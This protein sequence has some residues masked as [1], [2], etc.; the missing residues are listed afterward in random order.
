MTD[1]NTNIKQITPRL[2][3]AFAILIQLAAAQSLW[4]VTFPDAA[5][6]VLGRYSL[7]YFVASL[8][9][10]L[11][12]L[13]LVFAWLNWN[14]IAQFLDNISGSVRVGLIVVSGVAVAV[15]W[16]SGFDLRLL[17]Y[18]MVNWVLF[19]TV[20]VLTLP[21]RNWN[22][23]WW[24][25]VLGALVIVIIGLVAW[26]AIFTKGAFLPYD[27]S[28]WADYATSLF[29]TGGVHYRMYLQDYAVRPGYP[30][31]P[32]AY[33]WLLE[34][35]SYDARVG[36]I[37][38]LVVYAIALVGIWAI[39]RK[40]YSSS[41]AWISA[42]VAT[43]SLN[44]IAQNEFRSHHHIPALSILM[45]WC[46]WQARHTRGRRGLLW[47][48]AC[49]LLGSL[50]M[51]LHAIAYMLL[52]AF[53]IHLLI[54]AAL[55]WWRERDT[56][57]FVQVVVFGVG[58]ALGLVVYYFL[59]IQPV[60]GL[61]EFLHLLSQDKPPFGFRFDFLDFHLYESASLYSNNDRVFTMLTWAGLLYLLWR[62][63]QVDRW[64]LRLVVLVIA[65]AFVLD[66]FGYTAL[67]TSYFSIAIGVLLAQGFRLLTQSQHW[68]LHT[69]G[70]VTVVIVALVIVLA[71]QIVAWGL[72]GDWVRTG[73]LPN[74]YGDFVEIG[75]ILESEHIS[76]D[77]VIV[78][79]HQLMWGL[80]RHQSLYSIFAEQYWMRIEEP[81][82]IRAR[83][84]ALEPTVY[85][86]VDDDLFADAIGRKLI[87]QL[88]AHLDDREFA[89]CDSFMVQGFT[90]EVYRPECAA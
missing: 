22:P 20:L 45:L 64:F 26:T 44:F 3:V 7:P 5:A 59:N 43:L 76:D 70:V 53:G 33:G 28:S 39:A 66:F 54:D 82:A 19:A 71:T 6:V 77:D 62:R 56:Y 17:R 83:W 57:G 35:V 42:I 16:A 15:L 18:A 25:V 23:T 40:M 58:A 89:L 27:E 84:D 68:N 79:T 55:A 67:Y 60:G 2:V 75:A 85:I 29:R 36:H 61:E 48:F 90:V 9:N 37:W 31:I 52:G 4:D 50:G 47:V 51:E 1:V 32:V 12:I 41:V 86:K 63:T 69:S 73:E 80:P 11:L 72:L 10:P 38:M 74:P 13:V 81:E 24:R 8:F 21:D 34:N 87:N 46:A 65:I 14:R 88:N 78:S 49:G 30:L